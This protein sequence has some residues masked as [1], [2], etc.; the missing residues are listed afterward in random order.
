MHINIIT[1][2]QEKDNRRL[3]KHSLTLLRF[4]IIIITVYKTG[5]KHRFLRKQ[6]RY[7][8]KFYIYR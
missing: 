6:E 8:G 7:Y 4:S 3:K 2:R 5:R 1:R